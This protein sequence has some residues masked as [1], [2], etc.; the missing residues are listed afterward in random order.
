MTAARV[1][2]VGPT[3]LLV[4]DEEIVRNLVCELLTAQGYTVLEARDGREA[5]ETNERHQGRIDLLLTDVVMPRMSG[6]EVADR[7]RERR[8]QTRVLYM[9]GYADHAIVQEGVLDPG[10]ELLEKPFTF[11]TLQHKVRSILDEP[12]AA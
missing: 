9:T 12:L 3:V 4:E 2:P 5:L 11:E 8:P 10:T 7:L 6:R 1:E